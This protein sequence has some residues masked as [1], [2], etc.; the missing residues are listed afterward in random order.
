MVK[1][2]VIQ[3]FRFPLRYLK[4]FYIITFS[5]PN[6]TKLQ[7]LIGHNQLKTILKGEIIFGYL[8]NVN[9]HFYFVLP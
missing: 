6:L 3:F 2:N 5:L 7:F 9:K 4:I 8:Q 1:Y